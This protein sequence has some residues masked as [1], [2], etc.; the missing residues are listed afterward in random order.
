MLLQVSVLLLLS[1]LNSHLTSVV[2]FQQRRYCCVTQEQ[3]ALTF[4]VHG[5][6][7]NSMT[8]FTVTYVFNKD[9]VYCWWHSWF[10]F[11]WASSKIMKVVTEWN[12]FLFCISSCPPRNPGLSISK[13]DENLVCN[14][15][16]SWQIYC[17][18]LYFLWLALFFCF[19]LFVGF[20]ILQEISK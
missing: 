2:S 17:F 5:N 18:I 1:R 9:F 15:R 3:Q 6:W 11:A 19:V 4:H 13:E 16:A 20:T 14:I 10:G 8:A 7:K 12:L